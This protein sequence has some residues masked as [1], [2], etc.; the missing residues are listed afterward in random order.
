MKLDHLFFAIGTLLLVGGLVAYGFRAIQGE[1][2]M[3]LSF[4]LTMSSLLFFN[5]P[6]V[7]AKRSQ[8]K[9]LKS[10]NVHDLDVREELSSKSGNE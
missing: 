10:E 7:L 9:S 8:A 4:I 2:Y 5:L 1:G 3:A 6:A